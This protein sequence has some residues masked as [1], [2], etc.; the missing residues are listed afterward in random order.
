MRRRNDAPCLHRREPLFETALGRIGPGVGYARADW[1]KNPAAPKSFVR[2]PA[3]LIRGLHRSDRLLLTCGRLLFDSIGLRDLR[4][5][6]AL[7]AVFSEHDR[8]DLVERVR[9]LLEISL[10][11][12][13]PL[14][15]ALTTE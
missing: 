15:D 3:E 12:L 6:G 13:T 14:S 8:F 11:V 7:D 4:S 1:L 9:V 2:R 5:P 10:R